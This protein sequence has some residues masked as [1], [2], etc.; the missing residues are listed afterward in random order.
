M[1]G[2]GFGIRYLDAAGLAGFLEQQ[3]ATYRR[4]FAG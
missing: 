1:E 4:F 3:E 2:Q